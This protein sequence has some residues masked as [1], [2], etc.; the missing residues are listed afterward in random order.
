MQNQLTRE[1]VEQ[2]IQAIRSI[3]KIESLPGRSANDIT[4]LKGLR[5]FLGRSF[6]EHS[7]EFLGAWIAVADEYE[8]LV[9]SFAAL[10]YRAAGLNAIRMSKM[11]TQMQG[12]EPEEKNIVTLEPNQ[13]EVIREAVSKAT[14]IIVMP[15]HPTKASL[16]AAIKK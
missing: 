4:E 2:M 11:Q 6:F 1:H 5:E 7:S 3:T 14:N 9:H 13:R 8:P 15:D 12:E 10:Q 16:T